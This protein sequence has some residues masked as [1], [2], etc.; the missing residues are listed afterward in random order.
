M[1]ALMR[2]ATYWRLARLAGILLTLLL[3]ATSTAGA[4]TQPK[5]KFNPPKQ[6]YLS[7]GDSLGFGLQGP[8]LSA[9][10]DAGTYTPD[11]F[12]T[13]YTDDFAARMR[14]LRPGQQVV[15]LS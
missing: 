10:L 7:L 8:K 5:P 13:G 9:L 2:S 11:A 12:N 4:G 6:Y 1:G 14:Q 15:N 3:T